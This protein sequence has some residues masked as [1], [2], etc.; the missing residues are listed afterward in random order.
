MNVQVASRAAKRCKTI[1]LKK[2]ENFNK[3]PEMLGFDGE[4]PTVS[5][6]V[7]SKAFHRKTYFIIV[8][9]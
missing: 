2:I 4:C 6:S 3:I 5:K 8:I 1:N 7:V 9:L